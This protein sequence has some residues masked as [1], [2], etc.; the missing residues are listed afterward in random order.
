MAGAYFAPDY[1]LNKYLEQVRKD[2]LFFMRGYFLNDRCKVLSPLSFQKMFLERK[3]CVFRRKRQSLFR[4]KLYKILFQWI[5]L[6]HY[7]IAFSI[8][9]PISLTILPLHRKEM[10]FRGSLYHSLEMF[11]LFSF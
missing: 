4:R 3:K 6:I 5:G 11:L 9:R 2:K 10:P 1:D 8:K 7:N